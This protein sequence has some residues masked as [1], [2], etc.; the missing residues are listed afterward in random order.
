MRAYKL[1]K[2]CQ[3]FLPFPRFLFVIRFNLFWEL[4][5][6]H[7]PNTFDYLLCVA[8]SADSKTLYTHTLVSA[9]ILLRM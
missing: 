5:L 3:L 1:Y 9:I 2:Y 6:G 7:K 4:P 8:L